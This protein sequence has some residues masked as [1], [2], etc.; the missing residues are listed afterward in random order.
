MK[1]SRA[2][3]LIQEFDGNGLI[4]SEYFEL[5]GV[6]NGVQRRWHE[7]GSIFSEC[8]FIHGKLHGIARLWTAAGVC[9]IEEN[10]EHGVRHGEYT[11]R[12]NSGGLKEHGFYVN[13]K[14]QPGYKY[15]REDGSLWCESPPSLDSSE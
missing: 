10:F 11:S 2:P 3:K 13:G 4:K 8:T 14:R 12:W 1:S 9:Y 5:D 7:D 6:K 15:Y